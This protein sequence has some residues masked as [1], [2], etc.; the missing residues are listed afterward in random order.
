[1]SRVESMSTNVTPDERYPE[2]L[3]LLCGPPACGKS[4]WADQY[5]QNHPGSVVIGRDRIRARLFAPE[6]LVGPPEDDKEKLVSRTEFSEALQAIR[7]GKQ[8]IIDNL[9]LSRWAV[10]PWERFAVIH[11]IDMRMVM[12]EVPPLAELH[13]RNEARDRTIPAAIVDKNYQA[14]ERLVAETVSTES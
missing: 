1:M 14:W 5:T 12:L 9:N 11:N 4:T 3:L 7:A 10:E 6:Y 8:V 13:R 2:Q